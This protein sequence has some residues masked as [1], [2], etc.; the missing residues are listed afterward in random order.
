MI[1][2]AYLIICFTIIQLVVSIVNIVYSERFDT[3]NCN[4][5]GLVSILI[6]ARNEELNIEHLLTDLQAQDYKNIEI[7]VF[8][9]QSTDNTV[10]IVKK[11][12]LLDSRIKLI[13]SEGLPAGWLGKNYACHE[14]SKHANGKYFLFLD[15]DVRLNKTIIY[16]SIAKSEK[17]NL[18]LLSIFPEQQ[19]I[20]LGEK[21]TVPNMN[22]I[23][24]SLLP[25]IL[26]RKTKFNSIAAANGQYM[27]FQSEIYQS[28]CPHKKMKDNKVED[29]EIARYYK[30]LNFSIACM[31]GD[32]TISCRMYKGYIDAMNGFS[33]NIIS[34]FGDSF[35]L[36]YLFW[37]ITTL[38]F[39]IVYFEVNKNT[40][41]I[42]LIMLFIIR[43]LISIISKQKILINILYII[44]QQVTFGIILIKAN[45]NKL[46]KNYQWKGRNVY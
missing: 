39:V 18:G 4:F 28:I 38:G 15:A 20:T 41:M 34:F 6:P 36:A 14:L 2:I 24:L 21:I 10:E 16:Y 27:L 30:Q 25:L 13:Q 3:L 29:I 8:D 5:N 19:M 37:F 12:M 35:M 22:Y 26:V 11:I 46:K 33:K 44:P 32:E 9:D 7:L 45:L 1:Y 23:L 42:Y 31:T 40:F 17:N 43:I